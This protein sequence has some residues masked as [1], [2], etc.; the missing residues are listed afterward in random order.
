MADI[1][2][3]SVKFMNFLR[4]EGA[5]IRVGKMNIE[6]TYLTEKSNFRSAISEQSHRVLDWSPVSGQLITIVLISLSK[7]L[8]ILSLT[9]AIL[10]LISS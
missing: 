2:S 3:M 7:V 8:D 9:F 5:S 10:V 6:W 4:V 1:D